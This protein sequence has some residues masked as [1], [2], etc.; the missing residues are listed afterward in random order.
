MEGPQV[1]LTEATMSSSLSIFTLNIYIRHSM[2]G[3]VVDIGASGTVV[4]PVQDGFIMQHS[5]LTR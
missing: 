1:T 3:L 4:T 5:K 2:V